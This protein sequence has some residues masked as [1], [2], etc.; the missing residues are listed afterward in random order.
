MFVI[1]LWQKE[2][3]MRLLNTAFILFTSATLL[4]ACRTD[5]YVETFVSDLFLAEAV[6]TPAKMKVEIPS[7][8]DREEY[9]PKIL[10]LFQDDSK[11]KI[12]DCVDEGMN[13][14]LVVSM[15]A[16]V[17][18]EGSP[19]D[20]T[21]FRESFGESEV[22]GVNYTWMGVKPSINPDFIK[23]VQMLMEENLQSLKYENIKLEIELN[24][25]TRGS[26]LYSTNFA[27]VDGQPFT[28]RHRQP[29]GRRENAVFTFPDVTSDLVLQ[30]QQPLVLYAAMPK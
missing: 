29:L 10:A 20:L 5:F 18:T 3:T 15:T 17:S 25:D 6:E 8:G 2:R 28:A 21:L 14:M 4:A 23:R 30:N 27:W 13:S 24:N 26:I 16:L 9:E 7:C 19:A 1:E 12:T 11:A 22:E